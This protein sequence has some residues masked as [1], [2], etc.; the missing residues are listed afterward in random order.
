[1]KV[2]AIGRSGP[3]SL[4][5]ACGKMAAASVSVLVIL[6][7]FRPQH[8]A[9]VMFDTNNSV[10]LAVHSPFQMLGKTQVSQLSI[11]HP[12]VVSPL[13]LP[14]ILKRCLDREKVGKFTVVKV[15]ESNH[16]FQ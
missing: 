14:F 9:Y 12:G 6:S 1:M 5:F 15:C 2:T 3:W 13:G 11:V 10:S 8:A 4:I 16:R 7:H